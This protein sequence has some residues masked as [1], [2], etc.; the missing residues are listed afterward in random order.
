MRG[1]VEKVAAARDDEQNH[2]LHTSTI[3]RPVGESI[4]PGTAVPTEWS[5]KTDRPT[6]KQVNVAQLSL[7]AEG[8]YLFN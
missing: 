4:T 2:L 1:I 5:T 6:K 3:E 8:N 7:K